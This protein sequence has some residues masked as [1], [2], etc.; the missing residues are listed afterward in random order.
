[1]NKSGEWVK[2]SWGGGILSESLNKNNFAIDRFSEEAKNRSIQTIFWESKSRKQ[3]VAWAPDQEEL[4]YNKLKK[5][6]LL[7][8][9]RGYIKYSKHGNGTLICFHALW[10][11]VFSCFQWVPAGNRVKYFH[12]FL[13]INVIN[14]R[15]KWQRNIS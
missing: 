2:A 6:I 12:T 7:F 9:D 15:I 1:M 8:K 10:Q 4:L 13:A 11:S 5:W 3:Y 14:A